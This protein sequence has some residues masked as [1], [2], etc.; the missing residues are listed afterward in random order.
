MEGGYK[1]KNYDIKKNITLIYKIK[2]ILIF[3]IK[4]MKGGGFTA[5]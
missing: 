4:I 3:K 5:E 1:K 2:I